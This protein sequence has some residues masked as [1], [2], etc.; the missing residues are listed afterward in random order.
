M[1]KRAAVRASRLTRTLTA[2]SLVLVAALG[3]PACSS[4]E[5]P[6]PQE[7]TPDW[8]AKATELLSGPNWYRHA[9]FYEVYVRSFQ[10]SDGDGIGDFKGLTSKLDYLKEL[11]VDGIWLMPI[12]PSPFVDS[13]Y[14]VA[15]YRGINPEYGTMED[16]DAFLEAA[17]DKGIRVI[18]DLVLNHTSDQHSWF[19]ESR[20]SKDN[21]KA[22]WYVWSDT[23][24]TPDNGCGTHQAVFGDSAWQFDEARQQYYFH[25]FYPG[26]PDLNYENPE[27]V[28][29][30]L[31]IARFWLE[32]GVDGFRCDVISL[33]YESANDC[34]FLDKTKD[35]IKQ[36]RG[37][38]DEYPDAVLLA[39]P[40]DLS[41]STEYFGNGQDM[42]HMTFNFGYGYFWSFHF[43][44]GLAQP[45]R[46]VF[47]RTLDEYPV[48]AQD[49][50]VIGSHDVSRA[51]VNANASEERYKLAALVQL[52]MR[53]SPFIYY[54]EEVAIRP[55][56]DS[57]I[58]FRDEARSP[59][60]WNDQ[61]PGYGFTSGTPWLAFGPDLAETNIAAQ[62][63]SSSS[64][65]AFYRSILELRRGRA[66]WGNGELQLLTSSDPAVLAYLRF[67]AD[68]RYL[69]VLNMGFVD[70]Q[71]SLAV[72]EL[73]AKQ[74]DAVLGNASLSF[75]GSAAA[76]SIPPQ[77]YGVFELKE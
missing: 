33:L 45:I 70:S 62:K 23:E 71:T 59:L 58:D 38:V 63:A 43:G 7:Q 19:I 47:Q 51:W 2:T 18:I 25:R 69:V 49:A 74:A 40:T 12:M 75:E 13:G 10:D 24:G 5:S 64:M 8:D 52:T 30:T 21:P 72:S 39:E 31:D 1:G 65:Y 50:L 14:D 66:V 6:P 67:D 34:G 44:G 11:G 76:L 53:G 16:F 27:V 32:K 48:G 3:V 41:N 46:D 56:D 9:V 22:D 61:A 57:I 54:G 29:E 4:D 73:G 77:G 42:F 37:V 36:L 55:S 26:Q 17:H 60:A 68:L 15:D 20:S 28:K 35:Y